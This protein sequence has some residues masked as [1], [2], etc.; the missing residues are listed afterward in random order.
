M[1]IKLRGQLPEDHG[2][3]PARARLLADGTA[4]VVVAVLYPHSR[5]DYADTSTE[6]LVTAEIGSIEVMAGD[7]AQTVLDLLKLQHEQRTG[8]KPLPFVDSDPELLG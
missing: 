3:L 6:T 7:G 4:V 2:L 8:A 5:T 1:T